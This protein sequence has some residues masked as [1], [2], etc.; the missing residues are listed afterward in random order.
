MERKEM[1]Q[2]R[3]L[4][5]MIMVVELGNERQKSVKIVREC[6]NNVRTINL[7]PLK[8]PSPYTTL[9]NTPKHQNK[10]H[11]NTPS[12]ACLPGRLA[13]RIIIIIMAFLAGGSTGNAQWRQI[14]ESVAGQT[15]H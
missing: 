7:Q 6:V 3:E 12:H 14:P 8:H 4:V 15:G 1:R 10:H 9:P 11:Y 13:T 2:R 5:N